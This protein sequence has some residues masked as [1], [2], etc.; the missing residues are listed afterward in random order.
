MKR[1]FFGI[2]VLVAFCMMSFSAFAGGGNDMPSGPHYNLNIIGVK[3][4]KD[5]GAS[6]GHTLFVPLNGHCKI[7]MSQSQDGAF[8]VI[9]RDGTDGEALFNIGDSDLTDARTHY[10]VFA[11]AL[12]KPGGSVVITPGATFEDQLGDVYFYLGEI[13]ISRS[14]G[15]PKTE[16]ITGMFYVDVAI[17]TDGDGIADITYTREW[18]F[19]I[20]ELLEYWWD[21]PTLD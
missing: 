18:V 8:Q 15:K 1:M 3:S 10:L 17:D 11:R 16:N 5:V 13:T 4:D 9:D 2:A 7:V 12:G 6:N 21:S 14:A 20:P 19:D